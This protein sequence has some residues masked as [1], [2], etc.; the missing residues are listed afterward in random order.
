[1]KL[2]SIL[3]RGRDM[4][5][6]ELAPGELVG[7]ASLPGR[8]TAPNARSTCSTSS[9]AAS[10]SGRRSLASL[11]KI[12]TDDSVARIPAGRRALVSAR[13]PPRQDLRGRDEQLVEQRAQD[14]RARS[15]RV[16]L[17]AGVVPRGASRADSD[18]AVLRQRASR[19]RARGRHRPR[20]ARRA[21]DERARRR[22]RLHDLQRHHGQ[23]HARRRPLPL[24]GRSTRRR[25]IRAKRN[26]SSST[27]RT[28]GA[29]KART[30]SARWARGS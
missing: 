8:P 27:C 7:I 21:G 13:A 9:A 15:S 12:R 26:A 10:R 30:R 22:V 20:D 23:R 11:D 4:V 14:Q 1:M 3:Y 29:T 25:T 2:A 16:L 6:T 5:A 17:E 19:A 28:R 18:S 24:L